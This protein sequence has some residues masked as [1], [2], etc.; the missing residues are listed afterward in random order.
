LISTMGPGVIEMKTEYVNTV[1]L[2]NE[3][4]NADIYYDTFKEADPQSEDVN[5]NDILDPGEDL[6]GN[7]AL[8][9]A[10]TLY[11]AYDVVDPGYTAMDGDWPSD[12][13][14]VVIEKGQEYVTLSGKNYKII[15]E[16]DPATQSVIAIKLTSVPEGAL[17]GPGVEIGLQYLKLDERKGSY[18]VAA[19]RT[20]WKGGID[21]TWHYKTVQ[22]VTSGDDYGDEVLDEN[23]ERVK[24]G[25]YHPNL[26]ESNPYESTVTFG[27]GNT[28]D[29]VRDIDD[30]SNVRLVQTDITS[31]KAADFKLGDKFYTVRKKDGHFYVMEAYKADAK[32]VVSTTY[33]TD[34]FEYVSIGGDIYRVNTDAGNFAGLVKKTPRGSAVQS[35]V[36]AFELNGEYYTI[37]DRAD[38]AK[39]NHIIS[40]VF[41]ESDQVET[42]YQGLDEFVY[43]RAFKFKLVKGSGNKISLEPVYSQFSIAGTQTEFMYNNKYYT[44]DRT[45]EGGL[46]SIKFTY[47]QRTGGV[48]TTVP[49]AIPEDGIYRSVIRMPGERF[50]VTVNTKTGD[51]HLET[52]HTL[53]RSTYEIL[54]GDSPKIYMVRD[55]EP[56]ED[57]RDACSYLITTMVNGLEKTYK[58]DPATGTVKLDDGI[59]YIVSLNP[60]GTIAL[61][62]TGTASEKVTALSIDNKIYTFSASDTDPKHRYALDDGYGQYISVQDTYGFYEDGDRLYARTYAS[63]YTTEHKDNFEGFDMQ[64]MFGSTSEKFSH[65]EMNYMTNIA[66]GGLYDIGLFAKTFEGLDTPKVGGYKISY[67]FDVWVDGINKGTFR[68][69]SDGVDYQLGSAVIFIDK[70]EHEIKITWEV[71]ADYN[72][73]GE[74]SVEVKDVFIQEHAGRLADVNNDLIVND[75]DRDLV[76]GAYTAATPAV[77]SISL[78]D[79]VAGPDT[80]LEGAFMLR[81]MMF[82][83]YTDIGSGDLRFTNGRNDMVTG[84]LWR[85]EESGSKVTIDGIEYDIDKTEGNRLSECAQ[86]TQTAHK[87]IEAN[88]VLYTIIWSDSGAVTF[89]WQEDLTTKTMVVHPS[90]TKEFTLNGILYELTADSIANEVVLKEIVMEAKI[91][92]DTTLDAK[93]KLYSVTRY[94]NGTLR[95]YDGNDSV[96]VPQGSVRVTLDGVLYDIIISSDD[97]I[98]LSQVDTVIESTTPQSIVINNIAVNVGDIENFP[99]DVMLTG[100][101]PAIRNY[102]LDYIVATGKYRFTNGA[103]AFETGDVD[104]YNRITLGGVTYL[105]SV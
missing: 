18:S 49:A 88:G 52:E 82:Y 38:P 100:Q 28:Y 39:T 8:D 42:F 63:D 21:G 43:I 25:S 3:E 30:P 20:G 32:A 93:G 55:A 47:D 22:T 37:S 90:A 17:S 61:M 4:I 104:Q 78:E 29:I 16:Y 60:D 53:T 77:D 58:T 26:F 50:L 6:N 74:R 76:L 14:T 70:G 72:M 99:P 34:G 9:S 19:G 71:P 48:F 101:S 12:Y 86:P 13:T 79:N 81:G 23:G 103:D 85:S 5:G 73:T 95:F 46:Y 65:N 24:T 40:N 57:G 94:S 92:Y 105:V 51:I 98:T 97:K 64:K 56:T 45:T 54:I 68:I 80:P 83:Y 87:I 11:I 89:E 44:I 35:A 84:L 36:R 62:E 33:T 91:L 31:Y 27:G 69:W 1:K 7:G 15:R 59:V 96:I 67:D 102:V 75:T 41:D 66:A 10:E 2:Y